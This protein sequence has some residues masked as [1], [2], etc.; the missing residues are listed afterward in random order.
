MQCSSGRQSREEFIRNPEYTIPFPPL[1]YVIFQLP[2]DAEYSKTKSE[3]KNDYYLRYR[4]DNP[5]EMFLVEFL[6]SYQFSDI[7]AIKSDINK[8]LGE[9]RRR[10]GDDSANLQIIHENKSTLFYKRTS[11]WMAIVSKLTSY[12]KIIKNPYGYGHYR[13]I[14][15]CIGDAGEELLNGRKKIVSDMKIYDKFS[16]AH[17]N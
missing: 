1:E 7:A 8:R 6:P 12:V 10:N 5:R 15:L 17:K 3:D 2:K 14:Y 9:D 13:L 16:E 11:F 4:S